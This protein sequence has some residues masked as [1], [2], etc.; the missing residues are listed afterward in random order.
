[1]V[2]GATVTINLF[3]EASEPTS[4]VANCRVIEVLADHTHCQAEHR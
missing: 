3:D 4:R 1:M 2:S